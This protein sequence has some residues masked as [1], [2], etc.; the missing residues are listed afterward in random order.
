MLIK[1][2]G[3]IRPRLDDILAMPEEESKNWMNY[4]L[5]EATARAM[6]LQSEL[7][8]QRE[9][10]QLN[11]TNLT[12]IW[13]QI[14]LKRPKSDKREI[15]LMFTPDDEKAKKHPAYSF[16]RH[17]LKEGITVLANRQSMGWNTLQSDDEICTLIYSSDLTMTQSE[18]LR[19][20][21]KLQKYG[22]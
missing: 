11:R 18:M 9:F 6:K 16:F 14:E 22:I 8:A 20:G 4:I 13:C 10:N 1:A 15:W 17:V 21:T 5:N 3:I 12:P 19:R 7:R 2:N